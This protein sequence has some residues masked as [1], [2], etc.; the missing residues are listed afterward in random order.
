M[1]NAI[2]FY[3][4]ILILAATM[5]FVIPITI[6]KYGFSRMEEECNKYIDNIDMLKFLN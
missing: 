2:R 6:I 4:K 5:P 3:I 1:I